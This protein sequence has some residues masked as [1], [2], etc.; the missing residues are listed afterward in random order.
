M[1]SHVETA[2][3]DFGLP[4]SKSSWGE[5][6][7]NNQKKREGKRKGKKREEE[8]RREEKKLNKR[9]EEKKREEKEKKRNVSRSHFLVAF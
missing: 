5:K 9:K 8:K 2:F 1:K 6:T 3:F 4:Q 7:P